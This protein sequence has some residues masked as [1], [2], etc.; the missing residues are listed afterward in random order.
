MGE[1]IA[2]GPSTKIETNQQNVSENITFVEK[3]RKLL[4][5]T[6]GAVAK[7]RD[8][9]REKILRKYSVGEEEP[10]ILET[11]EKAETSTSRA[12]D[13]SHL[14]HSL[15]GSE[16]YDVTSRAGRCEKSAVEKLTK[17]PEAAETRIDDGEA[18]ESTEFEETVGTMQEDSRIIEHKEKSVEMAARSTRKF[19]KCDKNNKISYRGENIK[20]P[21]ASIPDRRELKKR[22]RKRKIWIEKR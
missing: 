4:A 16:L 8:I 10:K 12:N 17:Q 2:K 1:T 21:K 11:K 6:G 14:Y 19:K 13:K 15:A 20:M 18:V 22:E 3:E 9:A 5:K 7:L